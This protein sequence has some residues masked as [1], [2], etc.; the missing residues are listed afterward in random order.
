VKRRTV[1]P[2]LFHHVPEA[3]SSPGEGFQP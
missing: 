3:A 2:A 1:I